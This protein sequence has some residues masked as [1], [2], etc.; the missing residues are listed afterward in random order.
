MKIIE[1]HRIE[2]RKKMSMSS[3]ER[4][5]YVQQEANR[6]VSMAKTRDS[7]ELT[8]INQT[9]AAARTV[10]TR[11]RLPA[12]QAITYTNSTRDVDRGIQVNGEGYNISVSSDPTM[13]NTC[14]NPS[15]TNGETT[16]AGQDAILLAA[17]GCTLCNNTP[18]S[19][20]STVVIDLQANG[21]NC[22]IDRTKPPFAQQSIDVNPAT[23][24][25]YVAPYISP[26][27]VIEQHFFPRQPPAQCDDPPTVEL[28]ANG[29]S[30]K[31]GNTLPVYS[32]PSKIFASQ[33]TPASLIDMKFGSAGV[34]Q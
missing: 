16:F 18:L 24:Q 8:W 5:R 23:G 6:Y 22:C 28:L 2:R 26:C 31:L 3:S 1:A 9:K 17:A 13:A 27:V 11:N 29:V 30:V 12:S 19:Q 10:F 34:P 33:T 25:Y 15:V 4:L 21:A 7:S 20:L 32:Q 14:C